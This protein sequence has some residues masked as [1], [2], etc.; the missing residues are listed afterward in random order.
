[1][2]SYMMADVGHWIEVSR[3]QVAQSRIVLRGH[4]ERF[5]GGSITGFVR[6]FCIRNKHRV[7]L[8]ALVLRNT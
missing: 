6:F 5:P 2:K 1:M 7:Q 3:E 8:T 4:K